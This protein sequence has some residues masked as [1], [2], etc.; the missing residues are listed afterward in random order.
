MERPCCLV[1]RRF[2]RVVA[3]VVALTVETLMRQALD[4]SKE[5]NLPIGLGSP[6]PSRHTKKMPNHVPYPSPNPT[7]CHKERQGNRSICYINWSAC[8]SKVRLFNL[9]RQDGFIF[10]YLFFR[11]TSVWHSEVSRR[12][13]ES[14]L[15][16]QP[17]PQPQQH[18]IRAGST[19]HIAA[20]NIGSSTQ[21]ARPEMEPVSSQRKHPVLNR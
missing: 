4:S 11:P 15:R 9:E 7:G 1:L 18:W 14:E 16:M 19:T 12:G 6:L 21:W 20:C 10:I 13:V 5:D 17:T 3:L 2:R 8:K